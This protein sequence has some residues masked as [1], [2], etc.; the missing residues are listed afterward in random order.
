MSSGGESPAPTSMPAAPPPEFYDSADAENRCFLCGDPRYALLHEVRH[1]GFPITFR[2][3]A[4]GMVK[5]T[6]MP[7]DR[8]FEW[9]FN[10]EVF[11]SSREA[12][13]DRIWGFYDYFADE[14]CRLETSRRRFRRFRPLLPAGRLRILKIGPSTG[15]FLHVA[16]RE[17]HEALGVDVSS[18]FVQFARDTYGVR[19]DHGRFER[20]GY[21]DGSFDVVVLFNVV[22]NIPNLEEVLAEVRRVLRPGGMFV[23]NHVEMKGNLLAALQGDRYFLWRP[24]IC[25]AFDGGVARRLLDRFGFDLQAV[26]R[27]LRVLHMEKIATLL[28]WRW[29]LRLCRTLRIDRVPFEAWAYPSRILFARRR[30]GAAAS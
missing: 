21:P 16:Q 13:A 25:Y 20:M 8:F 6:P 28:H 30:E 29:L 23:L 11:F 18:R 12:S 7:N 9:F 22:E 24:P 2:R 1:F 5:Q 15:T 19:I 4:C 14:G 17:G 26:R 27:D 10:S 3:C